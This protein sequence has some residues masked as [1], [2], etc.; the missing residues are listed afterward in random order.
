MNLKRFLWK[1]R[2]AYK[3]IR[4]KGKPSF[5]QVGE[6]LVVDYIFNSVGIKKPTYLEIGTNQPVLCNNT[7]FFYNRGSK[8]VCIEP[9]RNMYE[10]I[11]RA[12]PRD[13]V[14]NIGIGLTDKEAADFYL[15]PGLLNGWSTFSQE[16]AMIRQRESG[17]SFTKISVPLKSINT[18]IRENF[19]AC[20]NFISI[21]VEGLDLDILKTIDFKQYRPDVIC[22]ETISFSIT[23]SETKLQDTI[24]FMHANGYITYA[25]TH[26]NTIFCRNDLFGQG[27]KG[28]TI[29]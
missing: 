1:C 25:D 26:V 10:M 16:E 29:K 5:S 4:A 21:D 18:V 27:Q 11:R 12:R 24:D 2:A 19:D 8:G 6:D 9:D 17:V 20:P 15:F 23:N 28:G 22:V 14:L 13:K 7:Y 3:I